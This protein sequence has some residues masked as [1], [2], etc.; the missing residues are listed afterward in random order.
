ML[1]ESGGSSEFSVPAPTIHI[2]A[3]TLRAR[4]LP[5]S[6]LPDNKKHVNFSNNSK[7]PMEVVR[8]SASF[9]G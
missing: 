7:D 9:G 5:A 6:P 1:I 3:C 2:L 4:A 8:I